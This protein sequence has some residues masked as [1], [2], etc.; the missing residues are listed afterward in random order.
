M[1][2][3]SHILRTTSPPLMIFIPHTLERVYCISEQTSN[4][5]HHWLFF[6]KFS[7]WAA[8]LSENEILKIAYLGPFDFLGMLNIILVSLMSWPI[9]GIREGRLMQNTL[10]INLISKF[11][12]FENE[13][14]MVDV[15]YCRIC[16]EFV[17]NACQ[18][19]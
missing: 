19:T 12:G 16:W 18:G 13:E 4:F 8:G 14:L 6:Y 11:K 10:Y 9:T 2:S 5:Y 15:V 1:Y 3:F 7:K 17:L